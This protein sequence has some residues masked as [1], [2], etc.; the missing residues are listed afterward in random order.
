MN[1]RYQLP[2][3]EA[4]VELYVVG[5]GASAGGLEA[6]QEFIKSIPPDLDNTAF[7]VAQH[8][9]ANYKSR[10]VPLLDKVSCFEV[11]EAQNG[12]L[13]QGGKIYVTPPNYEISLFKKRI[14]L[15]TSE[16]TTGP[17]P[18]IDNLFYSLAKEY[19]DKATAIIL[20]GTGEDGSKGL[21]EIKAEGGITIAQDPDTAKF[22]SMPAAGIA[23]GLV[24]R[25][26]PPSQMGE[27]IK[28]YSIGKNAIDIPVALPSEKMGSLEKI[29][30]LL[31]KE[32]G[33]DFSAYKASAILSRLEKRMVSLKF[34]DIQE[35]LE[36]LNTTPSELESL[37]CA[38]LTGTTA[39]FRDPE[40]FL[41]LEEYLSKIL[42]GKEPN[43]SI[44]IW[45]PGCATGEEV[46][47][48]A[49]LL[50]SLTK[51]YS[52]QP[53]IHIFATDIDERAIS[54]ARKA[55]YTKAAIQN[56]SKEQLSTYFTKIGNNYELV[57]QIRQLVMFSNHDVTSSPPF[58]KLDLI[59]C[60]NLLHF[61]DN[62]LQQHI[63]PVFHYALQ[64]KGYLFLGKSET[65]GPFTDLFEPADPKAK[66]YQRKTAESLRAVRFSGIKLNSPAPAPEKAPSTELS[67]QD[68]VKET[69]FKTFTHP[70]AIINADMEVLE[71]W[72]DVRLYMGLN[73]GSMNSNI[74]RMIKSDLQV[75]LRSVISRALK[76]KAPVQGHVKR[77]KAYDKETYVRI[78]VKPVL[79][80]EKEDLML[81]IFEQQNTSSYLQVAEKEISENVSAYRIIELEQE[82]DATK[83]HLQTF[84]E[85]LETTNEEL[86]ALNEE[87][88][89][90]NEELQSANE[91]LETTNEEL[92]S[93]N[94]EIQVAYSELRRSND[95][96]E[97]KENKLRTSETNL[98]A[99]LNSSLHTYILVDQHFKVLATN[100]VAEEK[101][102][103]ELNKKIIAG[104]PVFNYIPPSYLE[105]FYKNFKDALNGKTLTEEVALL[106][107]TGQMRWHLY[108]YT[109]IL[110][111]EDT[112]ATIV[113]ISSLD[114]TVE[115]Q[116]QAELVENE[117]ILD[118]VFKS[119]DIGISVTNEEGRFVKINQGFCTLYGYEHAELLGQEFTKI[120]PPEDNT[121][122]KQEYQNLL[123]TETEEQG[124]WKVYRKDGVVIDV[125]MTRKVLHRSNATRLVITTVRDVTESKKYRDLFQDTQESVKLGGWEYDLI[126]KSMSWTDEVYRIYELPADHPISLDTSLECLEKEAMP[127]LRAAYQGA[128]EK[129]EPFDLELQLAGQA[130]PRKWVRI[131]CKPIRI[132]NKTVKLFGTLQDITN[133]K[134]VDAEIRQKSQ[135]LNLL[136][137]N[138]PLVLYHIDQKGYITDA[139]GSGLKSMGLSPMVMA[140]R[141]AQEVF[142]EINTSLT[143]ALAGRAAQ[144]TTYGQHNERDWIFE[145]YLF[146][147]EGSDRDIIGFGLD[148]TERKKAE[149]EIR[150]S[151]DAQ[152]LIADISTLFIN[153]SW[154]SLDTAIMKALKSIGT[155]T[156]VERT[157]FIL[158]DSRGNLTSEPQIWFA[159]GIEKK[160]GRHKQLPTESLA[161]CLEK[162]MEKKV[163]YVPDVSELPREASENLTSK[164]GVCSLLFV[165]LVVDNVLIGC[166]G[167]DSL[168]NYKQ[169]DERD[170]ALMKVVAE[171]LSN[172]V[173]R[174]KTEEAISRSEANLKEAQ[175][176]AQLGN[177]Q[178]DLTTGEV[179]WSE[180]TLRIYGYT[181]ENQQGVFDDIFMRQN[182]KERNFFIRTLY[183]A[184]KK[185]E[186]YRYDTRITT[187][188]GQE[189]YIQI[190]GKPTIDEQGKVQKLYGTVMDITE[191][192]QSE[193]M[194]KAAL[195]Q[196]EV[197][198]KE[199][200]HRVKNNLAMVE[201]LLYLQKNLISEQKYID[202]FDECEKRIHSMALVHRNLYQTDNLNTIDIN[203]YLNEL[204][205][206]IAMSSTLKHNVKISININAAHFDLNKAIPLGL[207]TN[208]LVTNSFKY[209]FHTTENPELTISLLKE[210]DKHIFIVKD[211][212]KGYEA[213]S[214]K[215]GHKTLG[216]SLVTMLTTDLSGKIYFDST[217]GAETRIVFE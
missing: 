146:S 125:F 208:E 34:N 45:V 105:A 50:H 82:L 75:E 51:D 61:F 67:L 122:A 83:E 179:E 26:L 44:R 31:S 104:T 127:A 121:K 46:Y 27:E 85:E 68:K 172:A 139:T 115:R 176:V 118:T 108:T 143:K 36:Y 35:Y 22:N 40:A 158:F 11:L 201:G 38:I 60:R 101:T 212:G 100:K 186:S 5:I 133:R 204:V 102:L 207:I 155:T 135:T 98:R 48:I 56:L 141:P 151:L 29:Y 12:Q 145:N 23:S 215:V 150:Y 80:A 198:L 152:N 106:N 15:T 39:F 91:E 137:N 178:F 140:G 182:I 120:F 76:Q 73:Q 159:E 211:N 188:A 93:I 7:I 59:S 89:S 24:D 175:R 6:L 9:S 184:I 1:K 65:I 30:L 157:S 128:I 116:A 209:A 109:P 193:D 147:G 166:L 134:Q 92:Q 69:I 103:Q 111:K 49:I 214:S 77:I 154:K 205:Q 162:V 4:S 190:I 13:L 112:T 57:K 185:G 167:L 3:K 180:E 52:Q 165:P 86:Q 33:V 173:S 192:K 53:N 206:H 199:V 181:K 124:E 97:E 37:F 43:Q 25:V 194:L 16:K 195:N 114:I 156:R 217:H 58:L 130:S 161:W 2:K 132:Y 90:A 21:R 18:S 32:F 160:L 117:I 136:L 171:I 197:L 183:K 123:N 107:A 174:K 119:A 213:I 189:K 187:P 113:A 216:L 168:F 163:L 64:S 149:D 170:I 88:Q 19:K 74:L 8:I 71:I 79:H 95:F 84:I 110:A 148:I 54:V 70:Y 196:K 28:H 96:L 169:W 47:S 55:I 142:P 94:E 20:S 177:W 62:N 138:I 129:G 72:G 99:L 144:F 202:I 66:I 203:N 164:H 87:L 10:L 126:T 81:V 191:R 131:T 17:K 153:L 200:Y 41:A 210:D 42:E 63:I 78:T 14:R